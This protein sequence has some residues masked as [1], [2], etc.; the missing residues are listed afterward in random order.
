MFSANCRR[1]RFSSTLNLTLAITL[2]AAAAGAQQMPQPSTL[3]DSPV[4]Q[5]SSSQYSSATDDTVTLPAGTR[6]VLVL[7]HALDS[8]TT[9]RGDELYA[10]LSAPV[11]LGDRVA[12][13]A[14][15]FVQGKV[16]SM[17]RDGSR[18]RI[19][20]QSASL[21]FLDGYVANIRG[22]LQFVSEEGTAWNDP[23]TAAKTGIFV[24]PLLG[25]GIGL[26]IGSAFHES[27]NLGGMT[28]TSTSPEALGIGSLVG[29]GAGGAVSLILLAR[30]HHFYMQEGAP[31]RTSLPLPVTLSA[32]Q[33]PPADDATSQSSPP[34][35]AR[36]PPPARMP[37]STNSG[38]C[39]IPG[40]PGT[41]DTYIPG[42][43][44][45]GDSPG[46]PGSYIPGIPAT[47]PIP[48][49]CP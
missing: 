24:A 9:H 12:I 35:I 13:P 22:P 46:T 33:V 29:L 2:L 41:P 40:A 11:T 23:T 21:A 30:S 25:S 37:A 42:T 39:Y 45:I 26:A 47:P 1:R 3:P 19:T 6:L 18:A 20:M 17:K 10:Q 34:A 16:E 28:I 8:K 32:S 5:Q 7:T 4:A 43:P 15:T 48:Y 49:P 38:T 44:A 27:S 36:R 31:L 14:G